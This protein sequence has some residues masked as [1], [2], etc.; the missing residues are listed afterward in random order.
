MK[1]PG[2]P[3]TS[4]LALAGTLAAA[5]IVVAGVALLTAEGP[6]QAAPTPPAGGTP[7]PAVVP[8]VGGSGGPGSERTRVELHTVKFSLPAGAQPATRGGSDNR[9]EASFV[10]GELE[11]TVAAQNALP[12]TPLEEVVSI[13][14]H[15]NEMARVPVGD[16]IGYLFASAGGGRFTVVVLGR[17]GE[18][19]VSVQVAGPQA[20][21]RQ[22]IAAAKQIAAS[23]AR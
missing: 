7:P 20:R 8:G 13:Y 22:G 16:T 3:R 2:G 5:L 12:A 23:L 11:G 17:L 4:L 6:K 15:P 19:D 10:L 18:R 14:G 21:L 1:K 9:E